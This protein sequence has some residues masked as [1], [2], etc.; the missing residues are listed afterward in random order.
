MRKSLL[1]ILILINLP[2]IKTHNQE[3]LKQYFPSIET[4][5]YFLWE[6]NT[7]VNTSPLET[8]DIII[9]T[10]GEKMIIDNYTETQ[11]K[12]SIYITKYSWTYHNGTLINNGSSRFIYNIPTNEIP[13][14]DVIV[15]R[16]FNV[17]NVTWSVL[18]YI[19]GLS[20]FFLQ[21]PENETSDYN[22]TMM[23][24]EGYYLYKNLNKSVVIGLLQ[25]Y[26]APTEFTHA[27]YIV[28]KEYGV[29]LVREFWRIKE[30]WYN[31][32][33]T[34]VNSTLK[35]QQFLENE[36]MVLKDTNLFETK[37]KKPFKAEETPLSFVTTIAPILLLP[38]AITAL[39]IYARKRKL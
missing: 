14:Y 24:Y 27:K 7:T 11:E 22:F 38:I 1:I 29:L 34:Y 39:L 9:E 16:L 2:L 37:D 15:S 32:N 4:G 3:I 35:T 26:T 31:D 18:S 21:P 30:E 19:E 5:R 25:G 20:G 33:N 23:V 36:L 12:V 28:D 13:S 6:T 17:K 8:C 10:R